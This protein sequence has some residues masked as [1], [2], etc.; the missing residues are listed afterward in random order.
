MVLLTAIR[1]TIPRIATSTA[2]KILAASL[3]G[4]AIDTE[5]KK[6]VIHH[7]NIKLIFAHKCLT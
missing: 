4:F 5:F 6:K 3:R 1:S 7:N 2:P